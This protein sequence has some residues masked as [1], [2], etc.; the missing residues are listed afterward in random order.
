MK[1]KITFIFVFVFVLSLNLRAQN[2]F[3]KTYPG[4]STGATSFVKQTQDGGFLLRSQ[5]YLLK[6]DGSG[7]LLW[8]F[9]GIYNAPLS[10]NEN[11]MIETNDSSFV[12]LLNVD[13]SNCKFEILKL[14][15]NG[16]VVFSKPY[17]TNQGYPE[18]GCIGAYNRNDTIVAFSY[19]Y[20]N[21][22]VLKAITI[23]SVDGDTIAFN[24]VYETGPLSD[25]K[26]FFH[27]NNHVV[28][29]T[30]N[31]GS[32]NSL[33]LVLNNYSSIEDSIWFF[34]D[35]ASVNYKPHGF[36]INNGSFIYFDEVFFSN[37]IYLS[38]WENYNEILDT[39]ITITGINNIFCYHG[40]VDLNNN[41]FYLCGR[42][43]DYGTGV[44]ISKAHII[45][46]SNT[47]DLLFFKNIQHLGFDFSQLR[48]IIA[49]DDYIAAI[50]STKNL[51][52]DQYEVLLVKTD[53]NGNVTSVPSHGLAANVRVFPNPATDKLHV[54]LPKNADGFA[55]YEIFDL[56][57][58]LLVRSR[59]HGNSIDVSGFSQGLYILTIEAG[60]QRHS[61]K[62]VK[63]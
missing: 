4:F 58:R 10:F 22:S 15:K 59:L 32:F 27:D 43:V 19:T 2:Y 35:F 52:T 53:L 6:V 7:N 54:D 39:S 34:K 48:H 38:F 60:G 12:L 44:G 51:S 3:V 29:I 42:N 56:Q 5:S 8:S 37:N 49:G 28:F 61:V 36:N 23:S 20:D 16:N 33:A 26:Y 41:N 47:G 1:T 45:G 57:G 50:G 24:D 11:L 40:D 63:D 13:Y 17:Y 18:I 9:S 62:W 25:P 30:K 21:D 14:D 55:H 31:S 46:T